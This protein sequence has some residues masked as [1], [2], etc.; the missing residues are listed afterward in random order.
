VKNPLVE[1]E[2]GEERFAARAS[3]AAEPERTRLYARHAAAMPA[4]VGYQQ[5]TR[6][7]IPVILLER[8]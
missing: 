7:V 8:I 1:V 6:R 3:V 5:R 2:L 4:F